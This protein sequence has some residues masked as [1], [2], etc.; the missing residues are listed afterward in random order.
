MVY[1]KYITKK[2]GVLFDNYIDYMI[3]AL[4]LVVALAWNSA[5]QKY[6]EKNEYLNEQ[7]P[8]I[9]AFAVTAIIFFFITILSYLK[10]KF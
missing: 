2:S 9:Y 6:F 1:K 3:T 5:F 8:W 10:D 4:G 7:G